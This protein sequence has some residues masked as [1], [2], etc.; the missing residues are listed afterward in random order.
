[1]LTEREV[2]QGCYIADKPPD[3]YLSINLQYIFLYARVLFKKSI[4][5][6]GTR[7][8]SSVNDLPQTC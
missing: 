6:I 2:L 1:M 3:L 8:L 7:A 5:Y 4:H